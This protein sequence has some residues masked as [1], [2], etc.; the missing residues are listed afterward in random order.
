MLRS[1]RKHSKLITSIFAIIIIAFIGQEISIYFLRKEKDKDDI[2]AVIIFD[3]SEIKYYEYKNRVNRLEQVFRE[4]NLDTNGLLFLTY[5]KGIIEEMIL[6]RGCKR[7]AKN[8]HFKISKDE[9]FSLY[10]NSQQKMLSS[11]N[12]RGKDINK[13][14]ESIDK[15]MNEIIDSPVLSSYFIDSEQERNDYRNQEKIEKLIENLSPYPKWKAEKEFETANSFIDIDYFYVLQNKDKDVTISDEEYQRYIDNDI[16]YKYK[17]IEKYKVKYLKVSYPLSENDINKNKTELDTLANKFSQLKEKDD[18]F[19]QTRSDSN[20]SHKK[21]LK[22]SFI[23]GEEDLPDAIKS[24]T[25]KEVGDVFIKIASDSAD[26]NAIYKIV[27]IEENEGQKKYHLSTVYKLPVVSQQ[28]KDD[29]FASFK[30]EVADIKTSEQIE[31]FA[32]NK[33]YTIEEKV[34]LPETESIRDFEKS[35]EMI[36]EVNKKCR[37]IFGKNVYIIEARKQNDNCIFG[38]VSEHVNERMRVNENEKKKLEPEIKMKVRNRALL[39]MMKEKNLLDL[40]FEELENKSKDK[41]FEFLKKG[42]AKVKLSSCDIK[43]FGPVYFS[44]LRLLKNGSQTGFFEAPR[45]IIKVL[46]K[47][48]SYEKPDNTNFDKFFSEKIKNHKIPSLKK[49]FKEIFNVKVVINELV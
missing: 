18:V 45:G 21:G 8:M 34:F 35:R 29:F 3:G 7:I 49:I 9:A 33:K 31:E 26:Y 32:K 41:D 38:I 28:T 23:S 2:G 39:D 36:V 37:N 42:S 40:S 15:Q 47:S 25:K 13:L 4:N 48:K 6:E 1:I 16:F 20:I 10:K 44:S 27:K 30:T 24:A 19:A 17:E 43:D 11:Y 14:R 12:K 46:I 22:N 5:K